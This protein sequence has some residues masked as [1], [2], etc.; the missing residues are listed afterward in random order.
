MKKYLITA[1][2]HLTDHPMDEYR[3]EMLDTLFNMCCEKNINTLIIL[4]DI[5]VK[6]DRHSSILVNR[7]VNTLH[8]FFDANIEIKILMGNHDYIDIN[9]PYFKFLNYF[10]GC[11]M[12]ISPCIISRVL[13][14]PHG[15]N[16]VNV[17]HQYNKNRDFDFICIH[18]SITGFS[19]GY[20]N[21][22]IGNEGVS[23][24]VLKSQTNVPV[25]SGHIHTSQDKSLYH[26]I[27][28]PYSIAFG[29]FGKYRVFVLKHD[30]KEI[31]VASVD[32]PRTTMK[33][34][35]DLCIPEKHGNSLI[36]WIEKQNFFEDFKSGDLLRFTIHGNI[37]ECLEARQYIISYCQDIGILLDNFSIMVDTNR[38]NNQKDG[39]DKFKH[40]NEPK[41]IFKEY[42]D[43]NNL[44]SIYI[45]S[46]INIMEK[47]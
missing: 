27:G 11:N 30:K 22:I 23:P 46:G 20:N 12:I 8:N 1:D 44:D 31:E 6:K 33:K 15:F 36:P 35:I 4:G 14:I 24:K 21:I 32:L 40:I 13:Y 2:L 43:S 45:D 39:Y 28:A 41:T 42:C 16:V 25:F 3:W 17:L 9:Y 38:K 5:T 10:P 18:H 26:Y 19:M 47:L 37:D 34:V 29:D 7:F